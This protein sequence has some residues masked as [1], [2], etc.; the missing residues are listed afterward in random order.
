MQVLPDHGG[1]ACRYRLLN[2]RRMVLQLR[3]GAALTGPRALQ[4]AKC[5]FTYGRLGEL[6]T[7]G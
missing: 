3:A 5:G 7:E 2:N 6:A 4:T 1:Q